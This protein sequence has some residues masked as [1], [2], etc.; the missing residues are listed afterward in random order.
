MDDTINTPGGAKKCA[1]STQTPLVFPCWSL[2][3]L[4]TKLNQCRIQQSFGHGISL[5]IL[6]RLES[7]CNG[8]RM[9]PI[10]PVQEPS[11]I[12]A[13]VKDWTSFGGWISHQSAMGLVF[14]FTFILMG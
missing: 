12:G 2:M 4:G 7:F 6:M 10:Q 8:S 13:T 14:H 3:S 11:S 5:P 1:L 9:I